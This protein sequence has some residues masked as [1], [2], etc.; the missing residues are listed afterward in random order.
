VIAADQTIPVPEP[1][2]RP[3][4]MVA[5][6]GALVPLLREQQDDSERR[7]YYSEELHK[8]FVEAG[9]SRILQPRSFGGYEF[10]LE[11]FYRVIVAIST[12]DPGVGWCVCLGSSHAAMVASHFPV[13]VQAEMFAPDGDFRCPHPVAPTG[14]ATRVE[15]GYRLTGRWP[16]ASGVPYA[17]WV[18]APAM[19][20]GGPDQP[21]VFAV[22]RKDLTMLDDWG[23][24]NILGMNSSGSNSYVVEDAFVPER[25]VVPFDWF[26]PPLRTIGVEAHG[27]PLYIGR[28]S[29][30][31]HA[32]LVATMV[33]AAR[34]A[35]DEYRQAVMP[36]QTTFQPNV[37]RAQFH[38]DQRVYGLAIGMTD[39]A[40]A[41]LYAFG[42]EYLERATR[43]LET[44]EP[45]PLTQDA[46]WW[47]ML[48]QAGNLAAGAVETL[49]Y[50]A[51]PST[52]GK[53]QHMGRYFRDVTT[54]RQHV[55]AQRSDFAVRN[56][57]MYLG[58]SDRWL[59]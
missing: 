26:D 49:M 56:A 53:G 7:G 29:G 38:E 41:V 25:F 34:A 17:T 30:P 16:Y 58:E 51:P 14:E 19:I 3:E 27:N 37:P 48:Q 28:I 23:D 9:F 15:G 13:D 11:T 35:L 57:A 5:R 18:F 40:E 33:G 59:F 1:D 2:L 55:S 24:G 45:I 47:A 8:R 31:Y 21:H 44:D 12:G 22:P 54:Y 50:R 32:S 52:S 6:A 4:E 39:A 42:R 46:R 10:D 43:A 36:R 20:A